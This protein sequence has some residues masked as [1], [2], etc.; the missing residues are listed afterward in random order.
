MVTL[1]LQI[2][3]GKIS[4][5]LEDRER[6]RKSRDFRTADDIREVLQHDHSIVLDDAAREWRV[7]LRIYA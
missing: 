4:K 5:L 2:D 3:E 7:S 6:A 1:Q